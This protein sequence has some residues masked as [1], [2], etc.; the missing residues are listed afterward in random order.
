MIRIG[1]IVLWTMAV[2]GLFTA[3]V[4]AAEDLEWPDTP[5]AKIA[6]GYIE[7]FNANDP[8]LLRD[9]AATHRTDAALAKR[10]AEARAERRMA[11]YEQ[12][13]SLT[14]VLITKTTDTSLIVTCRA[15]KLGM[16]MS[17]TV[18]L[19]KDP[20]HKLDYVEMS[21]TSAPAMGAETADSDVS[22]WTT[23]AELLDTIR[24]ETGVP[25]IAAAV[26]ENGKIVDIAAIGTRAANTDDQIT[27]DDRWHVGS[28]TK[29]MTA[30]MIG[31]L[32][33][34]GKLSWETTIGDVLTDVDMNEA[35]RDV[36][37]TQLLRHRGGVKPYTTD[38]EEQEERLA[39][40]TG[41][42][43]EQR[44][45]F[46]SQVLKEDPA[47]EIDEFEY[48]N[49]GYAVVG[50]IA[51]HVTGTSWESLIEVHVFS[52]TG[53]K[54]AGFGWPATPGRPHE[55]RGHYADN[56]GF[57]VQEFGEYEVGPYLAPAG[58][59]HMSI[60]DLADYALLHLAGLDGKD[61]PVSA[62]TM[63]YLHSLP[64]DAA[65]AYAC[66]WMVAETDHGMMHAHGGSAGTLFAQLELYPD[67]N[68]A[69]VIAM[70]VG[71]E[72]M[73]ISQRVAKLV[74]K[75]WP[76]ETVKP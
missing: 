7:S 69:I 33:E 45:E 34:L 55:P 5:V 72:G 38:E 75:R 25:G 74:S 60:G 54:Q 24:N 18:N 58:D 68:R 3:A 51:E 70:N 43:T 12:I 2:F 57:R 28:I 35:Y 13:G 48:S 47:G 76:I 27:I 63:R 9:F 41:T 67:S 37:V 32:V 11:M 17:M 14:P 42:P 22:E 15:E 31:S 56:D 71:I 64:D 52:P 53:M 4:A 20:P 66:G 29:S 23:L 10:S 16:W 26:I 19:E 40:L 73:G 39:R 62:E 36:T 61:G 50:H 59:V 65:Q 46:V 8:D 44:R 1:A 21:P 30:T 6:R 49:A